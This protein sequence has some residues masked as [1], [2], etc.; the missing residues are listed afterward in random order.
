MIIL[1][2]TKCPPSNCACEFARKSQSLQIASCERVIST[3]NGIWLS[4]YHRYMCECYGVKFQLASWQDFKKTVKTANQRLWIVC[5]KRVC[6]STTFEYSRKRVNKPGLSKTSIYR[7][8]LPLYFLFFIIQ[9][10]WMSLCK[11]PARSKKQRHLTLILR[12]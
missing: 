11:R 6:H 5:R 2:S 12:I 7:N 10:R 3:G 4:F 9:I 8:I 1:Y